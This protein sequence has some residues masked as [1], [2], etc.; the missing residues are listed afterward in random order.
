MHALFEYV[1]FIPIWHLL[2]ELEVVIGHLHLLFLFF[3][4]WAR[5]EFNPQSY[6]INYSRHLFRLVVYRPQQTTDVRQPGQDGHWPGRPVPRPSWSESLQ[7]LQWLSSALDERIRPC[8]V[9]WWTRLYFVLCSLHPTTTWYKE[10]RLT[11]CTFG[12]SCTPLVSSQYPCNQILSCP[13]SQ[14]CSWST[15][16]KLG[17]T[18]QKKEAGPWS[19][20]CQ[21]VDLDCLLSHQD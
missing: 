3:S 20:Q 12:R 4:F 7:L 9:D 8:W 10:I 17:Q 19:Q 1:W 18:E 14:L 21:D 6:G 2:V 13:R 11:W 5:V 15:T 16:K